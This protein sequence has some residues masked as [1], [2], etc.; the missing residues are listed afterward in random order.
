MMNRMYILVFV[1]I[2]SDV[3]SLPCLTN[4]SKKDFDKSRNALTALKTY[5]DGTVNTLETDVQKT[6]ATLKNHIQDVEGKIKS[7]DNDLQLLESDFKA[8]QWQKYN[9]H[10]YY[11]GTE[12]VDWFTSERK[13]REI[14]GYIVKID[15]SSENSWVVSKRPKKDIYYWI[16]LT[17]LKEGQFRWSYDQS[18]MTYKYWY[19]SGGWGSKG[20]GYDCVILHND[21]KA[22]WLD[23][24]CTLKHYYICESNFCF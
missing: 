4:G 1:L 21:S 18:L 16:G 15:D 10:C 22:N 6:V 17:D 7:L 3:L 19:P 14:G 5:L 24:N 8:R 12:K 23:Y 20:Q 11:F 9:G 2:P 13:C